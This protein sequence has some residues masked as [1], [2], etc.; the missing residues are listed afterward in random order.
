MS[1]RATFTQAEVERIMRASKKTGVPVE[2]DLAAGTVRV[3]TVAPA[4]E[5]MNA[6]Q[7]WRAAKDARRAAQGR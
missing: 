4:A 1:R 6:L 7:K 5:Q 2:V 3:L